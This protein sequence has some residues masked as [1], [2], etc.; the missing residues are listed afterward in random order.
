MLSSERRMM[1][2]VLVGCIVMGIFGYGWKHRTQVPFVTV[3]L[4][5][6]TT[7]FAYGMARVMG[8]LQTGVEI[9]DGAIGNSKY[10]GE[11]ED[12]KGLL[13]QKLANYDE[14]VAENI[15]LRQMI[16][17][18]TETR[19]F[20]MVP[21]RII[22]RDIGGWTD[23]FTI[24]RGVEE[25]IKVNMPVIVPSGV[26]GYVT[27]VFA[28]SARVQTI[29]DPRSSIGVIVQ[30]PE[31]RV[32]S[33]MQGNGTN[34]LEP[35]M[36]NIARDSDVLTGDTI[37]TSGY[38]GIY[39]KGI[40]VGHVGRLVNDAEG[41]IRKAVIQPS[42]N[43]KNIEEVFIILHSRAGSLEKPSETPKLVPQTQRD[44]VEG[45]KGAVKQ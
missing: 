22:T 14:I 1:I 24:D 42:V 43:F 34:R 7:P 39:P 2:I 10:V 21:A 37:I 17:F 18:E 44:Q 4:E 5:Q 16:G 29:L 36:V 26:V 3:P 20:D 23:T 8:T 28:H 38:G 32:A 35:E 13:T 12:E 15:R 30:R 25:G 11:L 9:I 27:D 33:V 6:V 45:A 40:I 31:S 41:F 19:Q